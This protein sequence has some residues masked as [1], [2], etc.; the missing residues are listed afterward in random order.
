[1]SNYYDVDD[2]A[3]ESEIERLGTIKITDAN[4]KKS[5]VHPIYAAGDILH[6]LNKGRSIK[7]ILATLERS[8]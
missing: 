4:S 1:M 6:L 2:F 5:E 7:A 3:P 8:N